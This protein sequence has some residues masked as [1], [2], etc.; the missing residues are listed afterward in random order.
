MK[1][2]LTVI[3]TVFVCLILFG[4]VFAGPEEVRLIP[5]SKW[6]YKNVDGWGF[7][8]KNGDYSWFAF[9]LYNPT[10][11]DY[12]ISI[13]VD[14][15]VANATRHKIINTS[16]KKMINGSVDFFYAGYVKEYF[17]ESFTLAKNS[18]CS[19]F[20][21]IADIQAYSGIRMSL[22]RYRSGTRTK[23]F[24]WIS[25]GSWPMTRRIRPLRRFRS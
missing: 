18:T 17:T 25:T 20:M 22:L 15:T 14:A 7:Y 4:S 9:I 21:D 12:T 3:L 16:Y 10:N 5:V 2:T 11:T 8:A 24:R 1:K 19:V 6:N 13:P 23:P